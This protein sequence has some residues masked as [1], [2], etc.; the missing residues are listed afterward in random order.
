M[1]FVFAVQLDLLPTSRR[2]D[3]SHYVLPAVTLGWFGAAS[4]MRLTRSSMLAILDSEY[5]KFAKAKGV[6]SWLV[7]WKHAFRNS[8]IAPLTFAGLLL[9]ELITGTIIVETVFSWPGLG[10]LAISAVWN[11]DFPLVTGLAVFFSVVFLISSFLADILYAFIDPR[12]R[13][14]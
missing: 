3:W 10:S 8:L 2:G 13:Y 14:T 5:I 6:P 1:I 12:I 11:N 4:F 7:I 9:A